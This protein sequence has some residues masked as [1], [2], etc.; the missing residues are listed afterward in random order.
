MGPLWFRFV[1]EHDV[2]DPPRR[3]GERL[4]GG[5]FRRMTHVHEFEPREGGTLIRD[6][7]EIALPWWMGGVPA[8]RLVAAP[9]I[10][11]LFAARQEALE[12][13]LARA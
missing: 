4:V 7:L 12:R 2:H 1:F 13:I 6:R 9:R 5:P 8:E 3:F 11:A 10:R